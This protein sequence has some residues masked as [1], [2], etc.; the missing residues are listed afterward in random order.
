ML[1]YVTE[2][3]LKRNEVRVTFCKEVNTFCFDGK[4]FPLVEAMKVSAE[5][6]H[7]KLVE[8]LSKLVQK[9]EDCELIDRIS[10][11]AR[12]LHSRAQCDVQTCPWCNSD[13]YE[14]LAIWEY[15]K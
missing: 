14:H 12:E 5:F 1:S 11:A 2:I 8:F 9:A 10:D 13:K 6:M 4:M 3:D 15:V 7:N